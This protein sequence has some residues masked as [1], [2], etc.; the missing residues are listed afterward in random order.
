MKLFK[1]SVVAAALL[2]CCVANAAILS[3]YTKST[4]A[5]DG[6]TVLYQGGYGQTFDYGSILNGIAAGSQVALASSSSAGASTFDLFAG[7]SLSILQVF[8]NVNSTIFADGAYWYRNASSIGFAPSATIHQQSADV[9]STG[10]GWG[11]ELGAADGDLRLSW[12]SVNGDMVYGGWR[13]GLNIW[14]N[15]DN[16]WQ[17]YVLVRDAQAGQSVP[18]PTSL[19]LAGLALAGLGFTR[20]RK[21]QKAA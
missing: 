14:L 8:T 16:T 10:L 9:A 3:D 20:R 4:A 21:A 5:S 15:G 12:H 1:Y 2:S 17:R 19:A 18:E 13:S 11:P 6:W 7:T